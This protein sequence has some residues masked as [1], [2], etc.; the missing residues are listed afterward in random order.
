MVL[1][2]LNSL[3]AICK[4]SHSHVT[5]AFHPFLDKIQDMGTQQEGGQ[6]TLRPSHAHVKSEQVQLLGVL[7][8]F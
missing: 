5:K 4:L 1:S 2:M 8:T 7:S 3:S 6:S